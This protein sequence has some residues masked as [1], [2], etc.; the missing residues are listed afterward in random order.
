MCCYSYVLSLY[1]F[2][3]SSRRRHTRCALV[4]GLQTCAL[5][6]SNVENRDIRMQS[7]GNCNGASAA[8]RKTIAI[9]EKRRCSP[10][11]LVPIE[12]PV[13]RDR[14]PR[15]AAYRAET[16]RQSVGEGKSVSGRVTLGGRRCIE[17]KK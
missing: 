5:P 9:P 7:R 11:A 6:I 16:D 17:E 10:S 14:H 15:H 13:A 3:Y 1:M 12:G 2:F 8:D 4:T